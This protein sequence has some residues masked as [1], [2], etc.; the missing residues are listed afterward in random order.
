MP[1][2][3]PLTPQLLHDSPSE[4]RQNECQHQAGS[5]QQL[6]KDGYWGT[7]HDVVPPP[8]LAVV[9]SVVDAVKNHVAHAAAAVGST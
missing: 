3:L 9:L 4:G 8:A 2:D 1:C 6:H 5:H 7:G